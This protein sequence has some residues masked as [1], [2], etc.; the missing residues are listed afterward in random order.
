[1]N[2]LSFELSVNNETAELTAFGELTFSNSTVFR[3]QLIKLLEHGRQRAYKLNLKNATALDASAIELINILRRELS[4]VNA[5]LI[6]A[7]PSDPEVKAFLMKK[8]FL[9]TIS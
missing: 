3:S 6:L 7:L 1:M 5:S 9:P 2:K 8:G 4:A